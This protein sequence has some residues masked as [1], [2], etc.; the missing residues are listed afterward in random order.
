MLIKNF[1]SSIIIIFLVFVI[2]DITSFKLILNYFYIAEKKLIISFYNN[3][4][5][6]FLI[7]FLKALLFVIIYAFY[8]VKHNLR[9][10]IKFG[11][12]L[13]LVSMLVVYSS[14]SIFTHFQSFELKV[15]LVVILLKFLLAGIICGKRVKRS[16]LNF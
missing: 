6:F 7:T 16:F 1:I 4:L 11:I 14:V 10:G 9:Y 12:L 15:Y 5:L 2:L 8:S 3:Y 13:G